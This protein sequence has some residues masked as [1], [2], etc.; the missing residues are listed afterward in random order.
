MPYFNE[1]IDS[2]FYG[3][4]PWRAFHFSGSVSF[5][6]RNDPLDAAILLIAEN[7]VPREDVVERRAVGDHQACIKLLRF[8]EFHDV[9]AGIRIHAAGLEGKVFA[10]HQLQAQGAHRSHPPQ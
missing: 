6:G 3:P 2:L 10:I 1:F 9:A 4:R 5:V 7:I 8:N